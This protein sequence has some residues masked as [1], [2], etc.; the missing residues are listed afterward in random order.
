MSGNKID[1]EKIIEKY[2]NVDD[3]GE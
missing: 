2:R 3:E 1:F